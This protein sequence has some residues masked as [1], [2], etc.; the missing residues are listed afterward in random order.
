[1]IDTLRI[2]NRNEETGS[3]C[4]VAAS[5]RCAFA[6]VGMA[7]SFGVSGGCTAPPISEVPSPDA[8]EVI[9]PEDSRWLVNDS[10]KID[11]RLRLATRI[12]PLPDLG[13]VSSLALLSGE[14]SGHVVVAG[15]RGWIVVDPRTNAVV[16]RHDFDAAV[17][18]RPR[19]GPPYRARTIITWPGSDE[20]V[21]LGD[22]GAASGVFP[23]LGGSAGAEWTLDIRPTVPEWKFHWGSETIGMAA[24]GPNGE[25]R[26]VFLQ[27]RHE[28]AIVVSS[29]G[30]FIE[31]IPC[32]APSTL[33]P[34]NDGVSESM[35]GGPHRWLPYVARPADRKDRNWNLFVVFDLMGGPKI[36]ANQR[37]A[38][39]ATNSATAVRLWDEPETV[40]IVVA[41]DGMPFR[42]TLSDSKLSP[43]EVLNVPRGT[44]VAWG[45][46]WVGD[47]RSGFS[48][49]AYRG[50]QNAGAVGLAVSEP[51]V[52]ATFPDGVWTEISLPGTNFIRSLREPASVVVRTAEHDEL[53]VVSGTFVYAVRATVQFEENGELRPPDRW[54]SGSPKIGAP[55][56]GRE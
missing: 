26:I 10:D 36:I 24:T 17:A 15:E 47:K 44:Q 29:D 2:G 22:L 54:G 13:E 25:R 4:R 1:M 35:N 18:E 33:F 41:V 7:L 5:C 39:R 6:V 46:R 30:E 16:D 55:V 40:G 12:V 23:S 21:V 20:F 8:T 51:A 52:Q 37:L 45:N 49:R 27:E 3:S 9:S 19:M 56:G 11:P 28:S 38:C 42:F 34:M 14:R 50:V 32:P 48:A 31:A 43:G 53:W